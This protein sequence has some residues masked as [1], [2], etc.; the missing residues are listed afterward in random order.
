MR[1][2]VHLGVRLQ[3]EFVTNV[4]NQKIRA[5]MEWLIEL[6]NCFDFAISASVG[7]SAHWSRRFRCSAFAINSNICVCV[8]C[9][10]VGYR[11]ERTRER[12]FSRKQVAGWVVSLL[13]KSKVNVRNANA[14]WCRCSECPDKIMLAKWKEIHFGCSFFFS[15]MVELKSKKKLLVFRK[16]WISQDTSAP[17]AE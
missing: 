7:N 17:L 13:R 14:C 12:A 6:Q 10:W 5:Y 1:H 9:W 8:L 3:L 2:S 16:C 4:A 15:V 11:W